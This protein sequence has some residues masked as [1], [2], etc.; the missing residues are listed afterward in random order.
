MSS[1]DSLS[2]LFYT[3]SEKLENLVNQALAK[4]NLTI[5][6]MIERYY[7]IMSVSSMITILKQ[8]FGDKKGQKSLCQKIQEIETFIS[9]KFNS[10]LHPHI[11][12]NLSNS[13]DNTMQVLQS[14]SSDKKSKEDIENQ[15]KLYE[16]L[17]QTMSA[18]EFVEQYDKGLSNA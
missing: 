4:S 1:F 3:E 11:L 14:D 8:Q 7:Q 17:R 9:E 6:E 12:K 15:A 5:T 16:D 2:D 13:I 10:E 18:K